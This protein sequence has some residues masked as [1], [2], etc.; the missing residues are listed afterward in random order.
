MQLFDQSDSSRPKIRDGL[1]AKAFACVTQCPSILLQT[2]ML[3]CV[4]HT[5][6]IQL[7]PLSKSEVYT[8]LA[9][10]LQ[11]ST[12]HFCCIVLN[13]ATL[14]CSGSSAAHTHLAVQD[15]VQAE[16]GDLIKLC[17]VAFNRIPWT[18][19]HVLTMTTHRMHDGAAPSKP[20][21]RKRAGHSNPTIAEYIQ[22][23][24]AP[25]YRASVGR[26][27]S[28]LLERWGREKDRTDK[29]VVPAGGAAPHGMKNKKGSLKRHDPSAAPVNAFPKDRRMKATE[30]VALPM[31]STD[32]QQ[33]KVSNAQKSS[34]G[35]HPADQ[36]Q[37]QKLLFLRFCRCPFKTEHHF[38]VCTHAA[39]PVM[40]AM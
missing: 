29:V 28:H 7:M 38:L 24:Q 25:E 22:R 17:L 32:A 9:Q 21:R 40:C 10:W 14:Y 34:V 2:M 36:C 20:A 31:N 27:A 15:A 6:Q 33:F 18:E 13:L 4:Q 19:V 39:S 12:L 26:I 23:L 11:V 35:P 5:K 16:N 30:A 3:R 37:P 8:T 1:S